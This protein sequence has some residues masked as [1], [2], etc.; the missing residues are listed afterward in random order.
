MRGLVQDSYLFDLKG[1]I[2]EFN[3]IMVSP[4]LLLLQDPQENDTE[5]ESPESISLRLRAYDEY[6]KYNIAFSRL[7]IE[8]L[9]SLTYREIV[10]NKIFSP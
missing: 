4:V 2:F 1:V 9:I 8:G 6:E 7:V 10:K 3:S 5:V